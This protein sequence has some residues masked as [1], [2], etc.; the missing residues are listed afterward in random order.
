MKLGLAAFGVL[1][2]RQVNLGGADGGKTVV[3]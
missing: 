1:G 3:L 2:R